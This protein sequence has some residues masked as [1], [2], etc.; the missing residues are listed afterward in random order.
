VSRRQDKSSRRESATADDAISYHEFIRQRHLRSTPPSHQRVGVFSAKTHEGDLL[1]GAIYRSDHGE[2]RHIETITERDGR[3]QFVARRAVPHMDQPDRRMSAFQRFLY[4]CGPRPRPVRARDFA[5]PL[6]WIQ[7]FVTSPPQRATLDLIRQH[8]IDDTIEM[9][10]QGRGHRFVRAVIWWRSLTEAAPFF[11]IQIR[12]VL[13]FKKLGL[14]DSEAARQ[15]PST[16]D[17]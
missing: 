2:V 12:R 1:Q 17:R 7:F 16:D 13:P 11:W 9:Q 5:D 6:A 4:Y 15:R 8:L 3:I 14:E 10:L